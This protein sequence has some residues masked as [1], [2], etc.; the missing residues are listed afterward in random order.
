MV[1]DLSSSEITDVDKMTVRYSPQDLLGEL[2]FFIRGATK[3]EKFNPLDLAKSG[4]TLLKSLPASRS[5]IYEYFCNVF[6][7]AAANYIKG[8]ETEIKTENYHPCQKSMNWLYLKFIQFLVTLITENPTAWAPSI[9]TWS[10]ELLGEISTKYSGRAHISSNTSVKHSP[11]FDWV[12]AHVGSCFP[13]TVITRV[14]SC[15]LKDFCQNKS[16]EQGCNSPK[17]KSVVGILGH[18][19]DSHVLDIRRAI[20]E[21]FM[22]S[23]RETF[24]DTDAVRLQKK[25]TV[26]YIL[27]LVYL[28]TTLLSAIRLLIYVTV[29]VDAVRLS[30]KWL[31]GFRLT[32]LRYIDYEIIIN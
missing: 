11:N 1:F 12:V 22:R 24:D 27:Q 9:S 15:A 32:R 21:M 19:A 26:P 23:L 30:K 13:N 25:A 20:L 2:K 17:L 29:C 31:N 16:Y 18:L 14:L 8:I 7:S 28:S 10:L 3:K 4:L 5:A 6:D